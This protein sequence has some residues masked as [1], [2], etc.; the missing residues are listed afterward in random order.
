MDYT[1]N[2]SNKV[3]LAGKIVTEP[4]YSHEIYGEGFHEM[5]IVVSRLSGQQD[6]LPVTI[7]ERLMDG[8]DFYPGGDIALYGQ[9][10][11][12]NKIADGR[13]RLMLTIFVRE[14]A[15]HDPDMNPNSIELNGYVCKLPVYRTTPFKREISDILLAVNRAYNKSD[16]IPCIAWGRNARFVRNIAVGEKVS[17]S[18]RI[19]SREYQ[20]KIDDETCE[21]KV[22]YEVSV[23][24]VSLENGLGSDADAD[25]GFDAA[26]AKD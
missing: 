13:S 22:A 21:N 24:K 8:R 7:S 25:A 19:Q 15:V 1:E 14:L 10:R 11:S 5:N 6:V 17:I 23:N 3:Y 16:Y 18:G 2:S 4:A 9:F 20:K 26:A 12:Y